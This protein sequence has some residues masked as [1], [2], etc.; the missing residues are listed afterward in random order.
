MGKSTERPM[1]AFS[2]PPPL[3]ALISD[4]SAPLAS[5]S[6]LSRPKFQSAHQNDQSEQCKCP[7]VKIARTLAGSGGGVVERRYSQAALP[8][9]GWSSDAR[10]GGWTQI[11]KSSR[12]VIG[13]TLGLGPPFS[14]SSSRK[15]QLDC[16]RERLNCPS[17]RR[18]PSL[19]AQ[20]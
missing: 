12:L 6:H 18:S 4:R 1:G 2:P 19:S 11:C 5:S 7:R 9:R 8:F 14:R 16:A 15:S 17:I 13:V 10:V 3:R 20:P